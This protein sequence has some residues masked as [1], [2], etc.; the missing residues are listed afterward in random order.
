ML[1]DHMDDIVARG[2]TI[3]FHIEEMEYQP[4]KSFVHQQEGAYRHYEK[5]HDSVE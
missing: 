5:K 1:K 3:K 2:V 4:Q